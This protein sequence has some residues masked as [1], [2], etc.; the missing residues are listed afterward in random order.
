MQCP[1]CKELNKDRVIDSRATEAGKAI[2]R[3]R[4]CT[5]CGQRY[6]TKERIEQEARLTVAKKD[7]SRM[8]FDLERLLRGMQQ[9]CYKRPV[10]QEA[11][12][13]A[14]EAI[15][16]ELKKSF[17]REVESRQ[18]GLLVCRSLRDLDKVAYI[19]FASIYREFADLDDIIDDIELVKDAQADS[20]PDQRALFE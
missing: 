3:R 17:E 16:E 15:E 10:A 2:R 5:A 12:Q 11:I 19:R 4:E 13:Q 8:P 1:S 18:I 7:G 14:A 20:H 6:T 9:A